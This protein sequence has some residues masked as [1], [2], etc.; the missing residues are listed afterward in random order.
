MDTPYI[1]YE[2]I[3]FSGE[4]VRRFWKAGMQREIELIAGPFDPKDGLS[5]YYSCEFIKIRYWDTDEFGGKRA[6][7]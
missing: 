7:G 5:P 2:D 1:S 6:G 4:L 3:K